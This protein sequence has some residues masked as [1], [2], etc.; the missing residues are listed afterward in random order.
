MSQYGVDE[1]TGAG[2]RRPLVICGPG[3][4]KQ[5]EA[6]ACDINLIMAQYRRT[7]FVSHVRKGTPMFADVSDVSS[8]Q[9]A[10]A[11]LRAAEAYFMTL[12]ARVRETFDHNAGKF[13]DFMADPETTDQL[14]EERGLIVLEK[15]KADPSS[16]SS[17]DDGAGGD[18]DGGDGS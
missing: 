15:P 9:E 5:S 12:P 16:S 13:I 7:G 1:E 10:I 4:T 14:L 17:S 8:Y 2:T 18:G 6:A 3:R 11:N